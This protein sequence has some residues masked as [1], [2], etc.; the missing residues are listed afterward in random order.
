MMKDIQQLMIFQI[1]RL[2]LCNC[3]W[4]LMNQPNREMHKLKKYFKKSN[5]LKFIMRSSLHNLHSI[6]NKQIKPKN[7]PNQKLKIYKR[8]L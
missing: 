1:L 4:K 3:N 2:N 5:T 7:H 8:L 6:K